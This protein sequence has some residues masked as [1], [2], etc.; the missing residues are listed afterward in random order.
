MLN[1]RILTKMK[2]KTYQVLLFVQWSIQ[3]INEQ[4][5]TQLQQLNFYLF[6]GARALGGSEL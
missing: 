1:N 3:R 6:K 4:L 2:V 5:I